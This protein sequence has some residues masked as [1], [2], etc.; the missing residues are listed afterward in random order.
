MNKYGF[1]RQA[2]VQHSCS[3]R[4]SLVFLRKLSDDIRAMVV[5]WSS[6]VRGQDFQFVEILMTDWV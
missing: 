4:I 5:L 2:F 1:I 6:A 3:A